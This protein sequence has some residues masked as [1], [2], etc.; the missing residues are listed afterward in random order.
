MASI[1]TFV[2]LDFE[3]TGLQTEQPKITEMSM[4]AVHRHA[5]TNTPK[6]KPPR[7]INKLTLCFY[8]KKRLSAGASNITG[9]LLFV[10]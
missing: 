7:I 2:F 9:K 5:L 10:L 4:V 3:A 1:S 8:P 6:N